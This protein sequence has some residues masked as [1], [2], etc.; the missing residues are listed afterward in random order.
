MSQYSRRRRENPNILIVFDANVDLI[1]CLPFF[2]IDFNI[3]FQIN[4]INRL[5]NNFHFF[6]V[7]I[8]R[9]FKCISLLNVK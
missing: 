9:I 4:S 6:I 8:K 1:R 5:I 3:N 7:R 2:L